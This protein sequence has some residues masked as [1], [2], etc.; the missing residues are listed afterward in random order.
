MEDTE[1]YRRRACHWALE[2]RRQEDNDLDHDYRL[3]QQVEDLLFFLA[4][5]FCMACGDGR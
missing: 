3:L 5:V 2:V 1:C 4:D